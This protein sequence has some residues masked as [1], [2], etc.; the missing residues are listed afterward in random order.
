[1]ELAQTFEGQAKDNHRNMEKVLNR[2]GGLEKEIAEK[3]S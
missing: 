2:A 1:M 3:S